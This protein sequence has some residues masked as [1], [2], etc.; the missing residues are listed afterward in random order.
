MEGRNRPSRLPLSLA[1]LH[2]EGSGLGESMCQFGGLCYLPAEGRSWL[3][4]SVK[5]APPGSACGRG[6]RPRVLEQIMALFTD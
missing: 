2:S 3:Q 5:D 1:S 6:L 4:L